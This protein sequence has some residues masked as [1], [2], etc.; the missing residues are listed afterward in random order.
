MD[1]F[2][3]DE[4][5]KKEEEESKILFKIPII[6]EEEKY[7]LKIFPSRDNISIIFKLEKEYIQTY[8]YYSKLTSK[9][10]ISINNIINLDNN[11][12]NNFL[13]LRKI[14]QFYNC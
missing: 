14:T 9:D 3:K 1:V 11:I 10:F 5:S 6:F 2:E 12:N 4:E 13:Y 8:Y 7:S